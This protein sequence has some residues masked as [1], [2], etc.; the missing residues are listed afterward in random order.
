MGRSSDSRD[1]EQREKLQL[2]ALTKH[3]NI[4]GDSLS[5]R[6]SDYENNP[7]VYLEA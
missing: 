5:C 2:L 6:N 1:T 3:G 7:L 4:T